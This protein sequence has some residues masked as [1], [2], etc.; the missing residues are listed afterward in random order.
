MYHPGFFAIRVSDPFYPEQPLFEYDV[1][2]NCPKTFRLEFTIP[3]RGPDNYDKR[4][5]VEIDDSFRTVNMIVFRP[6]PNITKETYGKS[7]NPN[8]TYQNRMI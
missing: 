8:I 5:R 3:T 1:G 6:A 4:F 7:N 2:V